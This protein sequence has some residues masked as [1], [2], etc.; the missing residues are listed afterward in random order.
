ML[1]NKE[2]ETMKVYTC[3][4]RYEDTPEG[5]VI[6]DVPPIPYLNCISPLY[7]GVRTGQVTRMRKNIDREKLGGKAVGYWEL[8]GLVTRK[9]K[10]LLEEF[11]KYDVIFFADPS[12]I[13]EKVRDIYTRLIEYVKSNL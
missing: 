7:I 3:E 8:S 13:N 12:R 11:K 6:S 2:G 4:S 9:G 1:Q 5:L 10:V